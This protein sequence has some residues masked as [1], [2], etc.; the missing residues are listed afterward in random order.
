VIA[1]NPAK[2]VRWRPGLIAPPVGTSLFVV[3]RIARISM[4]EIIP[5]VLPLLAVMVDALM[6]ATY[7]PE[8]FMWLPR[9]FGFAR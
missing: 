5:P 7:V 2:L 1:V 4:T 3:C 8:T 9:M 6:L